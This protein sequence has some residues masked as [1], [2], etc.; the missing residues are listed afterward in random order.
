MGWSYKDLKCNGHTLEDAKNLHVWKATR[1]SDG[2]QAEMIA[3]EWHSQ[4]FFALIRLSGGRYSEPKTFLVV[5]LI[6]TANN[7]FGYKDG[8][9]DMGMY[10][11]NK[12]SRD[13]AALVYKHIPKASGYAIEFRERNGIKYDAEAQL[14]LLTA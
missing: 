4:T 5:D 6:D 11:K 1:Y 9:E 8:S 3:Y 12:P 13:F 2:I 7:Q 10:C 14:S